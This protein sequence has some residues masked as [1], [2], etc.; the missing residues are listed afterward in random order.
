MTLVLTGLAVGVA[1]ALLVGHALS[2]FLYGVSG[3]DPL[4]LGGA[5]MVLL[6]VAL[7]ACYLPARN[8][9]R[10]DPLVA[11]ARRVT[12]EPPRI[13]FSLSPSTSP[14]ATT[15]AKTVLTCVEDVVAY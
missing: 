12:S 11:F 9:S 6:G 14:D 7:V 13:P 1:L 3:S 8:A 2:R 15:E 5:S 4:S 10:V